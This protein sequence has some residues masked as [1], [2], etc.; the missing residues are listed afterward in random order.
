[1]L[2]VIWCFGLLG[3]KEEKLNSR[4]LSLA[5]LSSIDV[6]P[7]PLYMSFLNGPLFAYPSASGNNF[8]EFRL[9]LL[10]DA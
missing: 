3:T 9:G 7:G 6:Y 10:G 1:M 2:E 4:I 8:K 5:F